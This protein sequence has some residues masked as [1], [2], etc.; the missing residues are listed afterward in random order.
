MNLKIHIADVVGTRV[1]DDGSNIELLTQGANGDT[2]VLQLPAT[3]VAG[4]IAAMIEARAIAHSKNSP[5]NE[6][7]KIDV[8]KE[9]SVGT[10]PHHDHVVFVVD[11]DTP[12]MKAAACAPK[13]ARDIGRALISQAR[14]VEQATAHQN[15]TRN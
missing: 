11:K 1:S 2:I 7:M 6:A 15:R 4:A 5:V 12:R 9:W 3:K 14:A 10:T 8:L 13:T